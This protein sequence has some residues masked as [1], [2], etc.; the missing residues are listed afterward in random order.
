MATISAVVA[1]AR[2]RG[3]TA[4]H[5]RLHADN[6]IAPNPTPIQ[7]CRQGL[8]AAAASCPAGC[9]AAAREF[10]GVAQMVLGEV[11]LHHAERHEKRGRAEARARTEKNDCFAR[12][13]G[14]QGRSEID[15][16]VVHGE[17]RI[18][19]R[20]AFRIQIRDHGADI[21]LQQAHAEHDHHQ[22]Q[23]EAA[24]GAGCRQQ[25]IAQGDEQA[26]DQHGAARP[27]QPIGNPAAG[28]RD[29]IGSGRVHAVNGRGGFVVDSKTARGD[30]GDQEQHQHG[31]HAVVGESL[32]HLRE[33]QRGE[34]T[35][36]PEKGGAQ[37][38]PRLRAL[39]VLRPL[40][41]VPLFY[42]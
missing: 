22:A 5:P 2:I 21:G 17:S 7:S 6:A 29:Q 10:A 23:V 33:E 35:R 8:G 42:L 25:R 36:M 11:V 20:P 32:P 37:L 18:E 15:S 16:H 3:S 9:A 12:D 14:P 40:S 28:K 27:D 31:A 13:E 34:A 19:P 41:R 24:G 4:I 30:G 1:C 39:P 26:A 38:K